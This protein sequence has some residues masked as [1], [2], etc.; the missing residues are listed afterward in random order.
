MV[1]M[2]ATGGSV[3]AV[4]VSTSPLEQQAH[5][6]EPARHTVPAEVTAALANT[7]QPRAEVVTPVPA[8][9]ATR[10]TAGTAEQL[11]L[12][13]PSHSAAVN[14]AACQPKDTVSSGIMYDAAAIEQQLKQLLNV[15]CQQQLPPANMTA[16][17]Q[18]FTAAVASPEGV[19]VL[20]Q[21]DMSPVLANLSSNGCLAEYA[22]GILGAMCKQK[23]TWALQK[24]LLP[25][26]DL[27]MASAMQSMPA[28]AVSAASEVDPQYW[29]MYAVHQ[30]AVSGYAGSAA[31]LPYAG[32][33]IEAMGQPAWPQWAACRAGC[34]KPVAQLAGQALV[35][36]L[37]SKGAVAAWL[38]QLHSLQSPLL[39]SNDHNEMHLWQQQQH[40]VTVQNQQ[41]VAGYDAESGQHCQLWGL[42]KGEQQVAE[43]GHQ[44]EAKQQQQQQQGKGAPQ[45]PP[46]QHRLAQCIL[47]L[48]EVQGAQGP[49]ASSAFA[50]LHLLLSIPQTAECM[51]S[52]QDAVP[53]LL[54]HIL[55]WLG[56]VAGDSAADT[57]DA[58]KNFIHNIAD[59]P[60]GCAALAQHAEQLL[61]LCC[62]EQTPGP[63]RDAAHHAFG[64]AVTGA[65]SQLLWRLDLALFIAASDL[66]YVRGYESC[67]A[68]C[69]S[70]AG[71]HPAPSLACMGQQP[72]PPSQPH[73]F[74]LNSADCV[75]HIHDWSVPL[76]SASDSSSSINSRTS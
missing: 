35:A 58:V 60:P 57:C 9:N 56:S 74:C 31:V 46:G 2:P 62:H 5:T 53:T 16:A 38:T 13:A 72:E 28:S 40:S 14:Q 49:A 63:V 47:H 44:P 27:L 64:R 37:Q 51:L 15:C 10:H 17:V 43:Q 32:R 75:S 21:L 54:S 45:E 20:Q 68:A 3:A 48:L 29:S 66:A 8:P 55:V 73:S 71:S 18:A 65:G 41:G 7:I 52:T 34:S 67:A 36:A 25:H 26:I 59:Q 39:T 50:A 42:H 1:A 24:L 23:D 22:G 12:L 61:S 30:L 69:R 33:L 19:A 6:T 4:A 76:C 70:A 11:Q